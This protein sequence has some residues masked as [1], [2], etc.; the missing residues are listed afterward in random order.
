M[1]FARS[2]SAAILLIAAF[3]ASADAAPPIFKQERVPGGVLEQYWA[4]GFGVGRIFTPLTL[5]PGDPASPNPSGDNTVAVLTNNETGLGGIAASLTDTGGQFDYSFEAD[6]FTGG[7]E[8]RRGII[9]RA[10][11]SND[12]QTFYQF[13]IN[14]G[15]FQIRFRKFVNGAPVVPDLASWFTTVLPGSTGALAQNSW[16]HMEVRAFGNRFHCL[17]DGFDLTSLLSGGEIVDNDSPLLVGWVGAYNFS[18]SIGEVPVYFDNL[19]VGPPL[20][21]PVA[22]KTWGALKKLYR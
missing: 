12:F 20:P 18:A 9:V 13:V 2:V 21:T 6:F 16:H 4:P 17:L 1:S 22:S 8:T 10:D 14:A 5:S 3:A 15:L 19:R 7:G 11:P